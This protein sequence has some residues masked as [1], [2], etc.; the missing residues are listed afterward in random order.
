MST[1]NVD[2]TAQ[3][4]SPETKPPLAPNQDIYGAQSNEQQNTV[5][6]QTPVAHTQVPTAHEGPTSVGAQDSTGEV[7]I[8]RFPHATQ[9]KQHN[10]TE[11]R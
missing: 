10:E 7:E 11:M 6:N 8:Y 3:N 9:I 4:L 1:Q 2:S 5:V